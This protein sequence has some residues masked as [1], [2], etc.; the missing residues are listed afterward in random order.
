MIEVSQKT[1]KIRNNPDAMK[2]GEREY[3]PCWEPKV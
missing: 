3:E 2:L 1:G